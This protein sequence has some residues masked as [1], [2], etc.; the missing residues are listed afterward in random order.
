MTILISAFILLGGDESTL[1]ISVVKHYNTHEG[2]HFSDVKCLL[3]MTNDMFHNLLADEFIKKVAV[4]AI[5]RR[6]IIQALST[7]QSIQT[8]SKKFF[9]LGESFLRLIFA[10]HSFIQHPTLQEGHLT[11][12]IDSFSKT[13]AIANLATQK[14]IESFIVSNTLSCKLSLFFK[15]E[16]AHQVQDLSNKEISACVKRLIAAYLLEDEES[17]VNFITWLTDEIKFESYPPPS[18]R[19][20]LFGA[21]SDE[22]IKSLTEKVSGLE[23]KIAYEFKNKTLLIQAMTHG[24][25]KQLSVTDSNGRLELLGDSVVGYLITKC[26]FENSTAAEFFHLIRSHLASNS[27]LGSIVIRY[28]LHEYM[29]SKNYSDFL[30]NSIESAE[31]AEVFQFFQVSF[32]LLKLFSNSYV[33]RCKLL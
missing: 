11:Q 8:K 28:N 5:S 24:S 10:L 21:N 32:F 19:V 7:E 25:Y 14:D 2:P 20:I 26:L 6:L 27:H 33:E 16:E 30:R 18:P 12:L 9:Y 29:L 3:S 15:L 17:A 13:Q 22:H 23:A 4:S 1:D 31:Q